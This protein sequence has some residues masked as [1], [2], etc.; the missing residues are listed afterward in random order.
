MA[1][2]RSLLVLTAAE[3][4]AELGYVHRGSGKPDAAKVRYLVREFRFPAPIDAEL[5]VVDWRWSRR[6]VE[7][8]AAGELEFAPRSPRR[9]RPAPHSAASVQ[10]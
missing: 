7:S 6:L 2:R 5:P 1:A 10:S 9:R 8:Y 4:A 3:V